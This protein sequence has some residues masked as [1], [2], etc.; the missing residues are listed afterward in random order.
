MNLLCTFTTPDIDCYSQYTVPRMR[1]YA[2]MHGLDFKVAHSFPFDG[3]RHPS[4]GK[5]W[6]LLENLDHYENIWVIDADI[7]I[8]KLDRPIDF[9]L[10]QDKPLALSINGGNGGRSYH[11]NSLNCGSILA[12]PPAKDFLAKVWAV[13]GHRDANPFWEQDVINDFYTN[14]M[15]VRD[16]I[17]ALPTRA[18]NSHAS[19]IPQSQPDNLVYHLMATSNEQR[20]RLLKTFN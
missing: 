3:Y 8:N 9:G 11:F 15:A 13:K 18:I 14:D 1:T 17:V 5:I 7:W 2:A 19:D 4:W 6:L 20:V 16:M 10:M 12:R